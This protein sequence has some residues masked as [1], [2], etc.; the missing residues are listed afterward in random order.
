MVKM[1]C[2]F[3]V[4]HIFIMSPDDQ[5]STIKRGNIMKDYTVKIISIIDSNVGVQAKDK[6]QAERKAW[7]IFQANIQKSDYRII[8]ID[9]EEEERKGEFCHEKK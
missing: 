7:R 5:K 1:L 4:G 9:H 6:K 8:V 3:D 2:W